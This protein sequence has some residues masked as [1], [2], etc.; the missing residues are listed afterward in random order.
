[1]CAYVGVYKR[2]QAQHKE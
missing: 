2:L 1:M